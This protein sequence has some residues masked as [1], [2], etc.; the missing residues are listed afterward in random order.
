MS[1]G[2]VSEAY[3]HDDVIRGLTEPARYFMLYLMSCPHGNRLGLFVLA[4]AYAAEDLDCDT[5]TWD[6]A[7]VRGLLEELVEKERIRWD[8]PTRTVFVRYY[9]RHNVLSNQSVIKGA[10]NDL[11]GLPKTPLLGDLLRTV[12]EQ[13]KGENDNPI[14]AHYADLEDELRRRCRIDGIKWHNGVYSEDSHG[15]AHSAAHSAAHGAAHGATQSRARAPSLSLPSRTLPNL[16]HPPR[17]DRDKHGAGEDG[18]KD[19]IKKSLPAARRNIVAIHGGEEGAV[20]IEGQLVGVG[21][22][23]NAFRTWCETGRDP[24][25]I[26]AAAIAYLPD[27]TKLGTPVSLARWA[28][29]DGPEIYEQCVGRAYK[30]EPVAGEIKELMP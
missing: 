10:L 17:T 2:R 23:I 6:G 3:W 1:Y 8:R 21:V 9:L 30:A 22:E 16:T 4:P 26:I 18:L 25:D 7:K 12:I 5:G 11:A 28:A 29:K 14:R 27:V 20:E 19:E 13:R 15:A 24:P